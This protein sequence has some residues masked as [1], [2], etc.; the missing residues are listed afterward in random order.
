MTTSMTRVIHAIVQRGEEAWVA[1]C[2]EVAVVTQGDTL[3]ETVA[4][5]REAISL[6]LDGESLAELGLAPG[7]VLS[8][9][10][11]IDPLSHAA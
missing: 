10:V 2:Q 11:E 5:L 6:H 4:N 3:D 8:V 7:P 1:V 9:T